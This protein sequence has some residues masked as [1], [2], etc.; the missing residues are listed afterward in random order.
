MLPWMRPRPQP[1][2]LLLLLL[3]RGG[4][5]VEPSTVTGPLDTV[6]RPPAGKVGKPV[7]MVLLQGAEIPTA[8]YRPLA[9]AVVAAVPFPLAI[10]IP[11]FVGGMAEPLQVSHRATL[12]SLSADIHLNVRHHSYARMYL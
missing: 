7:G 5:T 4:A 1:P 9:E 3:M 11:E 6:V 12:W 10:A 8:R 2:L